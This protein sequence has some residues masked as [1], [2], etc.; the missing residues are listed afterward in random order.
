VGDLSLEW[1]KF[2]RDYN[3]QYATEA[4]ETER[5]QIFVKNVDRMRSY[6]KTHPDATFTMA[7]NHLADRRIEVILSCKYKSMND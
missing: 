2:K 6:Q 7:I 4:E 3:K 5:K 1:D